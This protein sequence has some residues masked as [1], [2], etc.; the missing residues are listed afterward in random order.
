MSNRIAISILVA[1][2]ALLLFRLA[3]DSGFSLATLTTFEQPDAGSTTALPVEVLDAQ[4]A[5]AALGLRE[6]MF[7]GRFAPH[8]DMY[9]H[10]RLVERIYPVRVIPGGPDYLLIDGDPLPAETCR[11]V[12]AQGQ[13][14]V[15]RCE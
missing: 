3:V 2:L 1:V 12:G 8:V 7:A 10:Q 6:V 5:V 15:V 11:V 4:R 13:V 9:L 14:R